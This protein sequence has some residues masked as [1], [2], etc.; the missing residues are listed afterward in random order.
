MRGQTK[1]G[2]LL[3]GLCIDDVD[4]RAGVMDEQLCAGHMRL[5]HRWLQPACQAR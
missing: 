5:S 3:S 2:T 1:G 4:R